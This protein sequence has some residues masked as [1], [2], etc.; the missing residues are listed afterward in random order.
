[1][2]W[3]AIHKNALI[4]NWELAREQSP[5]RQVEPLE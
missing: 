4:E 3:A 1:M 2:E 5:L